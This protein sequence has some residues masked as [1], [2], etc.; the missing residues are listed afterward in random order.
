MNSVNFSNITQLIAVI[1]LTVFILVIFIKPILYTSRFII[2]SA[3]F[4]F[5]M[6]IFNIITGPFGFTVGINLITSSLCGFLGFYGVVITYIA[7]ILY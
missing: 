3:L 5:L 1:T 2:R 7:R 4:S 6:F